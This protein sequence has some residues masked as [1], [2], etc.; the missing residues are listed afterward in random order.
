VVIYFQGGKTSRR[1]AHMEKGRFV[2]LE[3]IGQH[4]LSLFGAKALSRARM[5]PGMHVART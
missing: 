3:Q 1:R 2:R 5:N 4:T